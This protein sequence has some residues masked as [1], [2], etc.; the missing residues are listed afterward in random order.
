[1]GH[2]I[3]SLTSMVA[4]H[5][6]VGDSAL[7]RHALTLKPCSRIVHIGSGRKIFGDLRC[8]FGNFGFMP[9]PPNFRELSQ[10]STLSALTNRVDSN[11]RAEQ[12]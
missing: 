12:R 11:G 6:Y 3:L 10:S 1:M 4:T 2:G 5:L 9:T 8:N 7:V